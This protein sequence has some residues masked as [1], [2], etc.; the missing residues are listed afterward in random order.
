M[1]LFLTE[2]SDPFSWLIYWYCVWW[3]TS[4]HRNTTDVVVFVI[5]WPYSVFLDFTGW[6]LQLPH[7]HSGGGRAVPFG[8]R[9]CGCGA[10]HQA[11]LRRVVGL[12]DLGQGWGNYKRQSPSH[13]SLVTRKTRT[14]EFS[15]SAINSVQTKM[16]F[17]AHARLQTSINWQLCHL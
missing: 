4:G 14:L 7:P 9:V 6:M 3:G 8:H 13:G 10:G 5:L 1:A 17:W 2:S 15:A 12:E 16:M 11:S